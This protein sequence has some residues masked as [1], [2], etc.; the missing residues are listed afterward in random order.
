MITTGVLFVDRYELTMA[1]VY[2]RM[3]I[4]DRPARF[5]YSFRSYPDYGTHQAGYAV[6]AGVGPLVEWMRSERFDDHA[7]A[8][9][10][11]QTTST[12]GRLFEDGF[13][14]WLADVG[15]FDQVKMQAVPEGRVVHPNTPIAT[16]EAPLAIAQLLES[17][18]LNHLNFAS[19]IA[20]KASRVVEAAHG[21]VVL[22]F[23]MRRAPGF[24]AN[25]AT[26]AALIGG[27]DFS[28]NEGM[29][30]I[31]GVPA[32][33]THA[34]SLVQVYLAIGDGELDAFRAYADVYPDDCLLLVDTV[35]TLRSGLPNAITV[36]DEL[37]GRGHDPVGIRLDSGDLAHLA[38]RCAAV[39]DA[40]GYPELSIVLSSQLDEL[41]IW[42]IR[43]QIT[44]EA[45]QYGVDAQRLLERLTFGVGSRMVTSDGDSS[46]D[47][48]YKVAAIQDLAGEWVPTMKISDSPAKIANPGL[49]NLWR[50]Y[51]ERGVATA[52]VLALS[53]EDP[54]GRPLE[55]IHPSRTG[56]HRVLDASQVSRVESLLAPIA[57][58][59]G[60]ARDL[61][62]A[63]RQ[64]RL[65]DLRLLDPGVRRL[66][67]P[68]EYHVSL[69][70]RLAELKQ[71]L[72]AE[73]GS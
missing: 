60:S 18:L 67:N 73:Y 30:H 20:T 66:V 63:A 37:R 36:F 64:R 59:Q 15:G 26:R 7:L 6:M 5:E 42:Q 65:D 10:A 55:L 35:D 27:A 43:N 57:D 12:G 40:A 28:S 39:L 48:V 33:G 44:D 11:D 1:Q 2:F 53:D 52:D 9:L 21:G 62:I 16:I 46:F 31:L 14:G 51:D 8:V 70:R 58:E 41:A 4:A 3:G 22:E 56:V 38:V 50:V 49:K 71:S 45:P 54:G 32:K 24:G 23:G 69:T 17:S 34:H 68:H 29:S 72:I 61:L 25:A 47:G 19:L 13:L